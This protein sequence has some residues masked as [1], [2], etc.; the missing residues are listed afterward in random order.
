[1]LNKRASDITFDDVKK[2]CKQNIPESSWLDYKETF[3]KKTEN[4]Q[5][6]KIFSAMANT[7]GGWV[8]FG[9]KQSGEDQEGRGLPGD[10]VGLKLDEEPVTRLKSIGLD[11]IYPPVIPEFGICP[12]DKDS[13]RAII[14]ARI[15]ESDSAPHTTSEDR[16]Y[17]RN[18]DVSF[19]K[20][21]GK[22]ASIDDIESLLNGREK[23]LSGKQ[24]ILQRATERCFIP[25][26]MMML[27]VHCVPAYP[28]KPLVD[29]KGLIAIAQA[30]TNWQAFST[31]DNWQTVHE[32]AIARFGRQLPA[33]STTI[34]SAEF[35]VYGLVYYNTV[36]GAF[37]NA[38]R[39]AYF[40]GETCLFILWCVVMA[41][42]TFYKNA[43][44]GGLVDI[45]MQLKVAGGLNIQLWFGNRRYD[46]SAN[47]NFT[48]THRTLA[49]RLTEYGPMSE[50]FREFLWSSGHGPASL[51][52]SL[53][54]I[55]YSYKARHNTESIN[56]NLQ[57]LRN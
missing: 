40:S 37:E 7:H 36:I 4:K 15:F 6:G 31:V 35:N 13:S 43:N 17:I 49:H 24:L 19:L 23:P 2:F 20:L 22:D 28:D 29:L 30:N 25:G 48:A 47:P 21:D 57:P 51:T 8:L 9:I 42:D 50:L 46:A 18:N 12:L 44:Y 11:A 5:I 16:V 52:T 34:A 10:L 45:V 55:L 27:S 56:L 3:H 54:N 53:D 1:M 41:A 14:V 26:E 38:S 39:Q 32:G 33:E